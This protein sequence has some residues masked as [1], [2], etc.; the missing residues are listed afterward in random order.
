[1][2]ECRHCGRFFE[3][4]EAHCPAHGPSLTRAFGG[5]RL[6][7]GT[8]RLERRLRHGGM[9]VVAHAVHIGLDRAVA[10]KLIRPD[11]VLDQDAR[12][13]FRLEAAALGRLDHPA[14]VRVTDFGIDPRGG[15]FPYLVMEILNGRSLRSY[16]EDQ[17]VM[18]F[19]QALPI[20]AAVAA[21]LD[22][23]HSH[24]VIHRDVKPENVITIPD[25]DGDPPVKL[26][27]FGLARLA[28]PSSHRDRPIE[29]PDRDDDT[30]AP[31][32]SREHAPPDGRL[33]TMTQPGDLVGTLPYMAPE[34]LTDGQ[35]GPASDVYAFGVLA[36]ELLT[37]SPPFSGP[38]RDLMLGHVCRCPE[39]PSSCNPELPPEIDVP[40]AHA[41]AKDP[42]QRPS[43]A[44]AFVAQLAAADLQARRRR[45]AR[46]ERPRRSLLT[47]VVVILVLSA[48]GL[49]GR[50]GRLQAIEDVVASGQFSLIPPR[51]PDDR[52]LL[53]SIDESSLAEDP[54]AI[55]DRADSVGEV[56]DAAFSAGA[57][58]VGLDLVL[59]SQWAR[60]TPFVRL[61]ARHSGAV[62]IAVAAQKDGSLIGTECID[63]A[64]TAILGSDRTVWMLG[65]ANVASDRAGRVLRFE[66]RVAASKGGNL[67]LFATRLVEASGALQG[68]TATLDHV[69]I[70]YRIDHRSLDRLSWS[71]FERAV[72]DR[73]E[74]IAGRILI[75]GIEAAGGGDVFRRQP[76]PA[77]G[78]GRISGLALQGLMT[79][80]LLAG[81]PIRDLGGMVGSIWTVI[82]AAAVAGGL[83]VSSKPRQW[84]LSA[85]A[86][87]VW[88]PITGYLTLRWHG[89]L[90]P[91]AAPIL[92]VVGVVVVY[93]A[94]HRAL[95]P[96]P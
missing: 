72:T 73:P 17:G 66:P 52:L 55:I 96:R 58:A 78:D 45:W 48:V 92:S 44:T 46:R 69:W 15:G 39:P 67:P 9:G 4:D 24:G 53:V 79:Q 30:G 1:M 87:V 8:Y 62:V 2:L 88:F 85:A 42:T 61:I 38:A 16:L 25:H 26:V 36:Y 43:T 14:I 28:T 13:R 51:A 20:L 18:P 29:E 75:V 6:L 57:A 94:V 56:L 12:R 49:V 77:G 35:P 63:G 83:F 3:D 32:G 33:A 41:L 10:V 23:A 22:F 34:L 93:A 31:S 59:P 60:S 64:A 65:L 82:A 80:T 11:R 21:G 37:G 91:T 70:D 40:I 90:L 84:L 7:D 50:S 27:D 47:A 19:D 81:A 5:P 86:L 76:H 71:E 54:T 68:D 95:R 74:V 89:L